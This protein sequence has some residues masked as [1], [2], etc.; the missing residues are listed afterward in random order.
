MKIFKII[1]ITLLI[2]IGFVLAVGLMAPSEANLERSITIEAS[3]SNVFNELK[4]IKEINAWSPW[5]KIDPEGTKYTYSGP[6][7]G[8]GS[9]VDWKSEHDDVGVGSQEIIEI[10]VNSKVKTKMFFGGMDTPSYADF[11][12]IEENGSTKVIWTF[13]GDMGAN[14]MNR[15]FGLLLDNI[16][17]P[18]YE[19]GLQNLKSLVE[20]K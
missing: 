20:S 3:A 13:S 9:K 5:R 1:G 11:I 18:F 6:E 7:L 12:L 4:G 15:L 8:V 14:P 19:E 16:L 2:I 10:S 17:G